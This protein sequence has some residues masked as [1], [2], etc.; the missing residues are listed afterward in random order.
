[1]SDEAR[2]NNSR[3]Q[4]GKVISDKARAKMSASSF[5]KGKHITDNLRQAIVMSNK[6]RA[7]TLKSEAVKACLSKAMS[8]LVWLCCA[9]HCRRVVPSAV[10]GLLDQGWQRGRKYKPH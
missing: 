1:M 10:P 2:L 5:L 6:R 4:T 8:E 3:A 9:N 7:G